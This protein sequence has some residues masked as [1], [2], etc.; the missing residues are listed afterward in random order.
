MTAASST[1]LLGNAQNNNKYSICVWRSLGHPLYTARSYQ[2]RFAPLDRQTALNINTFDT[3]T[4]LL[5]S[6]LRK[7]K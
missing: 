6:N 2:S 1:R 7:R 4:T 5:V 3:S